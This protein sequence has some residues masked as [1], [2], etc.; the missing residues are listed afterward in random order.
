MAVFRV[1]LLQ[2]ESSGGDV[3]SSQE[4]GLD[5]CNRAIDLGAQLC[6]FPEMWNNGYS[7][8]E[9]DIND[10]EKVATEIDSEYV[11]SFRRLAKL[12]SAAIALT[13]LEKTSAGFR[14]SCALIDRKGEILFVYAKVHLVSTSAEIGCAAGDD[15]YVAD[16]NTGDDVIRIGVMICYDRE[17]PESA[18]VLALKGAEVIVTP[19]ACELESSRL[20]QFKSRAFENS[21]A[22][23]MVNYP[24]PRQ[25]G[26][27][28]NTGSD[29]MNG[30]S[31]AFSPIVF[32][33]PD[34]VTPVVDPLLTD[35]GPHAGIYIADIDMVAIRAYRERSPWTAKYR[36]PSKYEVLVAKGTGSLLEP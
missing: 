34:E 28:P 8:L 24:H 26:S 3:V 21:V 33:L 29:N 12:R 2:A 30:H 15:F 17:F 5:L 11:E 32:E 16:L 22:T 4:R 9:T 7:I 35:A 27:W 20:G 18:R 36:R 23:V 19:N 13:F 25:H 31:I 14:N 10:W 6:V 1:G